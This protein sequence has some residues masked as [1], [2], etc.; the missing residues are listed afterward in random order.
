MKSKNNKLS[1]DLLLGNENKIFRCLACGAEQLGS[2]MNY[3]PA[4]HCREFGSKL[5][6]EVG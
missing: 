5:V 4:P 2:E 1:L 6:E 3:H